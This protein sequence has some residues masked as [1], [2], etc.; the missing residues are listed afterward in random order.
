MKLLGWFKFEETATSTISFTQFMGHYGQVVNGASLVFSY[1]VFPYLIHKYGLRITLRIFPTLLLIATVLAFAAVP[2]NLA[3]LFV[4]M[5]ILKA[6]TYSIHDPSKELLYIPTSLAIKFRSKFWVDVV[7]ARVAKA[8]GSAI[9]SFAGNVE[10]SIR[11]G[12]IPSLLTA[13]ALWLVCYRAGIQFDGL[14]RDDRVV[15]VNATGSSPIKAAAKYDKVSTDE[16]EH[17][18]E[19][20]QGLTAEE[21]TKWDDDENNF[22]LKP[23]TT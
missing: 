15:G 5:A 18:I 4:C 11:V 1:F 22:E 19:D 21:S 14:V 10:N 7:G 16:N 13:A 8:F 23:L 9:N 17:D 12:T 2:G 6:M 3:V 20:V